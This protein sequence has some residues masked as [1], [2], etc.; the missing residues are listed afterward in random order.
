MMLVID[1]TSGEVVSREHGS[2]DGKLPRAFGQNRR[3]EPEH[4]DLIRLPVGHEISPQQASEVPV[5]VLD[6]NPEDFVRAMERR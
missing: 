2:Q 4:L 6:S 3:Y 1:M 5:D